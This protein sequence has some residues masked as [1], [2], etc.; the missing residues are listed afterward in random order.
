MESDQLTTVADLR[1]LVQSFVDERDWRQ[2]HNPKNLALSIAIEAA[3]IMERFQWLSLEESASMIR[4]PG[5]LDLVRDELADVLIYCLALANRAEIDISS[6]VQSKLSRNQGRY[7][8]G[9]MPK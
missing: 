9:Y 2:Y 7:P 6:A 4:E 1:E 5:E 8:I 3:E